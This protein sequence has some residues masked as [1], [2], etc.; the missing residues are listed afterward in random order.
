MTA[1]KF[2]Q[3]SLCLL[4]IFLTLTS[5]LSKQPSDPRN[6]RCH[7]L[8]KIANKEDIKFCWN[9]LRLPKDL[10]PQSYEVLIHPDLQK[11]TFSGWSNVEVTV[12]KSTGS[13]VLHSK[14]LTISSVN[15]RYKDL[16]DAV[17]VK[18]WRLDESL[19]QMQVELS[20]PLVAGSS[21]LPNISFTGVIRTD[22]LG[23]YLTS[24]KTK[25]NVVRLNNI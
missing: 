3:I 1:Q 16:N 4:V 19:E 25:E 14:N 18:K 9:D 22:S 21:I 2:S 23:F 6:S 17:T 24:Y 8:R 5:T 10:I 12:K 15:I 11:S 13:I 7:F 20:T